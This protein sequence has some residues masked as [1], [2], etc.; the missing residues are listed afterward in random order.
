MNYSNIGD[1]KQLRQRIMDT[2]DEYG[3]YDED[4]CFLVL[5]IYSRSCKLEVR[6][7]RTHSRLNKNEGVWKGNSDELARGK[8]DFDMKR[9]S[10]SFVPNTNILV[11]RVIT[12]ELQGRFKESVFYVFDV[13]G[14]TSQEG[15][16]L[17]EFM[18]RTNG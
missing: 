5:W 2:S 10:I 9:G 14:N 12:D 17:E 6:K 11:Q 15:V 8:F 16:L 18:G 1:P 13:P 4:V 3:V 7:G